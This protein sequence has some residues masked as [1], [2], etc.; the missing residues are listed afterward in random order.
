MISAAQLEKQS[1]RNPKVSDLS[2]VSA[3]IVLVE[4][5][6]QIAN[7]SKENAI[8]KAMV[9]KLRQQ[10]AVQLEQINSLTVTEK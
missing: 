2:N 8:L 1:R 7:L 9:H 5:T 4:L 6:N 10:I 3:D